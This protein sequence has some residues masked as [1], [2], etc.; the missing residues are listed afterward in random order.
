MAPEMATKRLL[1]RPPVPADAEAIQHAV[2][3]REVTRWLSQVPYPYSLQD[4]E[5][6]IARQ[7]SGQTFVICRDGTVIGCIGT[8]GEF[9]Y[10]LGRDHWGQGFA[11]EA[12]MVVLD[13]HF[14]SG[15]ATLVSGHAVGNERSRRVLLKTGFRDTEVVDRT[16]KITGAKRKQQMMELTRQAWEALA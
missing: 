7:T 6:F 9:G 13:W 1:L 12:A 11:T 3:D 2:N 14:R 10:W 15:G 16:H 4:A 8:M 5:E